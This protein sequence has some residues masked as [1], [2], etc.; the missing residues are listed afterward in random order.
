MVATA[1]GRAGPH[2]VR[3]QARS[4]NLSKPLAANRMQSLSWTF[5][6][7]FTVKTPEARIRR[8]VSDEL[9]AQNITSAGSSETEANDWQVKPTSSPSWVLVTI[10]TPVG[11]RPSTSRSESR[12]GGASRRGPI[13]SSMATWSGSH[14]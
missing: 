12:V 10:V 2:G 3:V 1:S 4:A 13:L 5:A 14:V 9:F 7:T 6:S 8:Q 11:N